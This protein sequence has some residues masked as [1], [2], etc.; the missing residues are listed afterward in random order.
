MSQVAFLKLCI[1][2]LEVFRDTFLNLVTVA[3]RGRKRL[4]REAVLCL[5]GRVQAFETQPDGSI[6]FPPVVI[7]KKVS[8][9]RQMPPGEQDNSLLRTANLGTIPTVSLQNCVFPR[10][11]DHLSEPQFHYLCNKNGTHITGRL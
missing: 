6:T 8:R 10:R 4:C 2:R 5:V 3:F 11:L 7:T 9:H 1:Q